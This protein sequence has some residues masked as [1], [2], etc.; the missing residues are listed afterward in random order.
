M[1]FSVTNSEE[2]FFQSGDAD[3]IGA[4][5]EFGQVFIE[6]GKE[7]FEF[8][9]HCDGQLVVDLSGYFLKFGSFWKPLFDELI[10][11]IAFNTSCLLLCKH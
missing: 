3:P 7:V 11:Y 4:Q 8:W 9:A 5:A 1:F 2:Y 10:D 6:V